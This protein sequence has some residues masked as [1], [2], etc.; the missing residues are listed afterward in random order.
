IEECRDVSLV[1]VYEGERVPEG[2][3]SVTLRIGYRAD[4]RTLRD[5]E[6]DELHR[7]IVATLEETF[8]S[9]LK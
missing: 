8:R 4:D 6:V 1:Y 5:D 7:R 3:R 9:Q 2:Q